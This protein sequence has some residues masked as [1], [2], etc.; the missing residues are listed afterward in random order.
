MHDHIHICM[1]E[2]GKLVRKAF[3]ARTEDEQEKEL[4]RMEACEWASE[5]EKKDKKPLA[6]KGK[7]DGVN[8]PIAL[9]QE[10]R[11][12]ESHP[13]ASSSSGPQPQP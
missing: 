3:K 5:F 1:F 11:D 10:D 7:P 8:E 2:D 9:S 12:P 13:E 4:I 6:I